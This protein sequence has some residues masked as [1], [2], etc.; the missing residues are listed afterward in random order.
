MSKYEITVKGAHQLV[1]Q[2]T[3]RET[4]GRCCPAGC[5]VRDYITHAQ[6]QGIV[7][8]RVEQG[9]GTDPGLAGLVHRRDEGE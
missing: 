7:N 9:M 8:Q 3:G 6:V 2:E 5:T 1:W 4:G